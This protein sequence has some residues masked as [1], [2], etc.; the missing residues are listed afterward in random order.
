MMG[1]VYLCSVMFLAA[2]TLALAGCA[3]KQATEMESAKVEKSRKAQADAQKS[4]EEKAAEKEAVGEAQKTEKGQ[5]DEYGING[6]KAEKGKES[7]R[8]K[9]SEQAK[10]TLKK[11]IHFAF[12]SSRLSPKTQDILKAKAK[13]LKNHPEL[14][15]V[16]AG[17][18]DERG[19]DEYNIALGER[20]AMAAYEYLILLGVEADRMDL[21]S[22]G[23]ERPLVEGHNE[24]AWAKNRRDEFKISM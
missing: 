1:R 8:K 12:D 5:V 3:Q 21:V 17:H 7:A 2:V 6:E 23:E 15:M 20:R 11:R 14:R 10:Q 4:T 19:T 16:I 9:L 13:I 18:C 22:Y 24:E